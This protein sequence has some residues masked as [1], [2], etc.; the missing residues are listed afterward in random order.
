[1]DSNTSFPSWCLD[2]SGLRQCAWVVEVA[3]TRPFGRGKYRLV[4][5]VEEQHD[6]HEIPPHPSPGQ[7]TWCEQEIDKL[8]TQLLQTLRMNKQQGEH[9][10]NQVEDTQPRDGSPIAD[11][12][13]RTNTTRCMPGERDKTICSRFW[14]HPILTLG[15]LEKYACA[16]TRQQ[17]QADNT[18]V[19]RTATKPRTQ[20]KRASRNSVKIQN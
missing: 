7:H 10:G 5:M 8:S 2:S 20:T 9:C 15:G 1:M 19:L 16:V 3:T 17:H 18:T 13:D 6:V 14:C 11:N 12:L 4:W